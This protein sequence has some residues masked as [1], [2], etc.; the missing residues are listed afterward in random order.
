MALV[1]ANALVSPTHQFRN[2]DTAPSHG[3][4]SSFVL[5]LDKLRPRTLSAYDPAS[6][7][8]ALA[9]ATSSLLLHSL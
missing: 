1:R 2:D 4:Q 7:G 5:Q 3:T 6:E 9:T 8:S